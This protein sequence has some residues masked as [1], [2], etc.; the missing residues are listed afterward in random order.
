MNKCIYNFVR[1]SKGCAS[2]YTT[3]YIL[4]TLQH[5]HLYY[6]NYLNILFHQY[7]FV[8]LKKNM[9]FKFK[10]SVV[11]LIKFNKISLYLKIIFILIVFCRI[12][13]MLIF[14]RL[15][16]NQDEHFSRLMQREY[17][18]GQRS[19]RSEM[20]FNIILIKLKIDQH[21]HQ[22]DDKDWTKSESHQRRGQTQKVKP[23]IAAELFKLN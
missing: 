15:L 21:F 17:C 16:F 23:S 12:Y 3:D 14:Y 4:F 9:F 5:I 19:G 20:I 2:Q 10:N 13:V 22:L 7:K 1:S 11:Q 6:Q 18:F 8:L